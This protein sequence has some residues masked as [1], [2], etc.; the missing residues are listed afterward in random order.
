[1]DKIVGTIQNLSSTESDLKQLK[2]LLGK[3]ENLIL[4]SIPVLDEVLNVLDPSVHSLGWAF[5]L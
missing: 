1:M 4:K 2:V 3:E 5:I